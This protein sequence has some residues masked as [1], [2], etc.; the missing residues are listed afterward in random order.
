MNQS[1]TEKVITIC[2]PTC[3]GKT[4]LAEHMSA[5]GKFREAVSV[6][7][8]PKRAHEVDGED[9]FFVSTV[10]FAELQE[11]EE[12]IESNYFGSNWYGVKRDEITRILQM[13]QTPITVIEPFGA[14]RMRNFCN[15]RGIGIVSAFIECSQQMVLSRLAQRFISDRA[16]IKGAEGIYAERI[17][18]SIFCE[19]HWSTAMTYDVRFAGSSSTGDLISIPNSLTTA[20]PSKL[21]TREIP[22]SVINAMEYGETEIVPRRIPQLISALAAFE[23][24]NSDELMSVIAKVLNIDGRRNRYGGPSLTA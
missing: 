7:T 11:R 19:P 17:L 18:K 20:Q 1:L 4:T 15:A 3:S 13:G 23:G 8:R 22:A 6:T 21:P 16:R 10:Q 2:G 5:S 24:G 9:Y 12:L 14:V